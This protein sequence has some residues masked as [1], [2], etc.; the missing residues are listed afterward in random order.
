[1]PDSPEDD[2]DFEYELEP[3]DP[4][5]LELERKRAQQKT[6]EAISRVTFDEIQQAK[7]EDHDYDVDFS[8][9]KEFRFTTRHLLLLTAVVAFGL[10]I[11]LAFDGCMALFVLGV[12]GVVAGWIAVL[13]AERRRAAELEQEREKFLNKQGASAADDED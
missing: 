11:W 12:C 8:K 13:R 6:D 7:P 4:E 5:I 9:L 3:V 1:M 2:D 10:T